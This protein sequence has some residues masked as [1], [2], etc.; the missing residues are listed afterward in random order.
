MFIDRNV[1]GD[2]GQRSEGSSAKSSSKEE[3][4]K[5]TLT[6]TRGVVERMVH[7]LHRHNII[8]G[9]AWSRPVPIKNSNEVISV[10]NR[11]I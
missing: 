3:L 10:A 6:G 4:V 9:S 1:S 2:S 11:M 7:L 8:S 5:M